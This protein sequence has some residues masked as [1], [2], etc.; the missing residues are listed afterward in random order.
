M[1]A[2]QSFLA[3]FLLFVGSALLLYALARPIVKARQRPQ[4]TLDPKLKVRLVT[5][6]G[7]RLTQLIGEGA[8]RSIRLAPPIGIGDAMPLAEGDSL[9]VQMPQSAGSV[10]FRSVI[11]K[12]EPSGDLIIAPPTYVRRV[13]RR[14]EPRLTDLKRIAPTIN[15]VRAEFIDL[16]AGGAQLVTHAP[17][18]NGQEVAL[19]WEGNPP[20]T[21]FVLE[22]RPAPAHGEH[23]LRLRL[24]FVE[25][26]DGLP[27]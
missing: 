21:A 2:A 20:I 11:Q 6:K 19:S 9:F 22:A 12:V 10:S 18:A 13:E 5:S 14:S 4:L 8:N 16:S 25:P 24:R 15:G 3:T 27:T 1:P 23:A 26:L 7:V 17:I